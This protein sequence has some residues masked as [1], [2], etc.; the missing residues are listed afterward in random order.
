MLAAGRDAPGGRTRCETCDHRGRKVVPLSSTVEG[1]LTN[2]QRELRRIVPVNQARFDV[3]G[4]IWSQD[5]LKPQARRLGHHKMS[6]TFWQRL[7]HSKKSMKTNSQQHAEPHVV[8]LQCAEQAMSSVMWTFWVERALRFSLREL[9]SQVGPDNAFN[10]NFELPNLC[11]CGPCG[12]ELDDPAHAA[13]RFLDSCPADC[14][15]PMS[16]AADYDFTL[17]VFPFF[18][19]S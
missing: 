9:I 8:V 14:E 3:A 11:A 10:G 7:T 15:A 16:N 6:C 13:S 5:E 19:L 18:C 1:G 2:S 17:R 12:V 4:Q